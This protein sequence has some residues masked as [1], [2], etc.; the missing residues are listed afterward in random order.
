MARQNIELGTAPTGVGGDTPRSANVKINEMTTELYTALGGSPLPAA[1]PVTKGGTGSINGYP[2]FSGIGVRGAPS[3]VTVQGMYS[4]W[5]ALGLGEGQFVVNKGGGDGGFYWRSV[6]SDN[7]QSGPTMKYAYD[8]TL[9]VT[10]LSVSYVTLSSLAITSEISTVVPARGY[11]CRTGIAGSY[12][13]QSYN[14]NWTGSNVDV[15][16]G[17]TYVGTMT[18]FGSDYR[19][20]KYVKTISNFKAFD[21]ENK[22]S[23]FLDRNDAYRIVT[24]QRKN[25][26][27]VFTGDGTVYQGLIAHEAQAVNPLAATGEKDGVDEQGNARVQQ[28]DPMALIT[29][30]MG[31]IKELH[32][33]VINLS[34]QLSSMQT[35]LL[36]AQT[37]I[38][39]L[40]T[41]IA[42]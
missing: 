34:A 19:F 37:E 27:D 40:R 14:F 22:P 7:S 29:D 1:L 18:L 25:F 6:N 33:M 39:T 13:A 20:K 24:Y 4:G 21:E 30:N 12:T 26:G 23:S 9:T 2:I 5:N 17:T 31:A 10:A 38:S 15:Y 42:Q 16:I 3:G 28:L 32:A 35:S 41:Q 36:Q 11:Q 8:G